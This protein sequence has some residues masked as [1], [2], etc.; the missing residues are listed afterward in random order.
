MNPENFD[1]W[2][3]VTWGANNIDLTED[4]IYSLAPST[5]QI[6]NDLDDYLT[7][8]LYES[9]DHPI[10]TALTARDV[11]DFLNDVESSSNGMI[12][13]ARHFPEND[14]KAA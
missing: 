11:N 13:V 10:N 2:I 7:I 8:T 1:P 4:K 9:K 6:F 5:K 14:E 3:I 12:K